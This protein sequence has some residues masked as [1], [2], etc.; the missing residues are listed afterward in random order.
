MDD[1]YFGY[2]TKLTQENTKQNWVHHKID[3]KKTEN[4]IGYITRLTQENKKQNLGT[5]KNNI[6]ICVL[7]LSYFRYLYIKLVHIL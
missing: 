3:P 7:F 1:C 6:C 2:I 5:T 4:K